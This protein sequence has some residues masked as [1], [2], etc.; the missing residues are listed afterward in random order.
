MSKTNVV[1][2]S[3]MKII[4]FHDQLAVIGEEVKGEELVPIALNGFTSSWQPFDHGVIKYE[5]MEGVGS[6]LTNLN[7]LLHSCVIFGWLL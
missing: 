2:A 4:E 5:V 3:L 1:A 6:Q 7:R